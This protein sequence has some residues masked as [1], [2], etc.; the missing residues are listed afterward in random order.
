MKCMPIVV[1]AL[2]LAVGTAS[3]QPLDFMPSARPHAASALAAWRHAGAESTLPPSPRGPASPLALG[4]EARAWELSFRSAMPRERD[5]DWLG[6]LTQQVR[7]DATMHWLRLPQPKVHASLYHSRYFRSYGEA[8]KG[9]YSQ[10]LRWGDGDDFWTNNV[11]HPVMGALYAYTFTDYDRRCSNLAY[12]GRG[13]WRCMRRAAIYAG[14]ASV[15]WEWS[16]LMSES[17]FGNVGRFY[18]CENGRCRGE[19][20]WTDFVVTPLGGMA[21]RVTGDMARTSLWPV[22]DRHL[23]SN[24]AAAAVNY[25]LKALSAPG[26][27]L[28]CA[29]KADFRKAWQA[30]PRARRPA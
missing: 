21:I 6:L 26:H 13:Y 28:N 1:A 3:G 17:A 15:N 25:T 14:L 11:G 5:I 8:L 9:Y 18:T 24:P 10:P 19:G 29:F 23:S 20:G 27:V 2:G 22:L 30:T 4:L 7:V 12:G 16:P